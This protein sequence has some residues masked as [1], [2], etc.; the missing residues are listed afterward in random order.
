M[1]AQT[2]LPRLHALLASAALAVSL[3]ATA[4][5]SAH[6]LAMTTARV[7]LRDNQLE[8]HV[9]LD[10]LAFVANIAAVKSSALEGLDDAALAALVARAEAALE[11]GAHLD[12]DGAPIGLQI[13]EFPSPADLRA[14]AAKHAAAPEEHGALSRVELEGAR[15]AAGAHRI[16]LSLPPALGEALISFVQPTTRWTQPGVAAGFSVLEARMEPDSGSTKIASPAP[17]PRP[18][19]ATAAVVLAFAA[20]LSNLAFRQKTAR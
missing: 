10:A 16:T 13:R 7:S 11:A 14:L 1:S 19:L 17:S 15:P 20:M 2:A 18:W 3:A 9:E 6:E 5:A 12:A 4:P 8:V